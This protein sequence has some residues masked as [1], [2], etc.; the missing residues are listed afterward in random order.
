MSHSS[1]VVVPD[2]SDFDFWEFV[3]CTKCRMP[4]A[5]E[6][7]S[8][9]VP[10]WLTECGHVICNNHLNRDQSCCQCGAQDIQLAP[11]QREMEAPMSDWFRPVPLA[12]D[13]VLFAAKFQQDV[14][15]SQIRYHKSR[16]QQFRQ[17]VERMK[18]DMSD[19]KKSHD[20]LQAQIEGYR[21]QMGHMD[22]IQN[23]SNILNSNG[24]RQMG[25]TPQFEHP[26]HRARTDSSPRLITT[27]LGPDRLTLMPG[28]PLPELSST[29]IKQQE[30]IEYPQF[31]SHTPV[32]QD[33]I[34][35]HGIVQQRPISSRSLEHHLPQRPISS[36]SLEQY[37][38]SPQE[39]AKFHAPQL[40]HAQ[41]APK[42]FQRTDNRQ[43]DVSVASQSSG[44]LNNAPP[45]SSRFKPANTNF[46]TPF[47]NN[48]SR[49]S[50]TRQ[51]TSMGP[52]P[53]PQ[54]ARNDRSVPSG[55]MGQIQNLISSGLSNNLPLP[56]TDRRHAVSSAIATHP[57]GSRRFFPETP[58]GQPPFAAGSAR[59]AL[60]TS[61]TF[62]ANAGGQKTPL[63]PDVEQRGRFG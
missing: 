27:P 5:L 24:K 39:N 17:L 32:R 30:Q 15:A 14:M 20:M 35:G 50:T 43:N 19:L 62:S 26:N 38:Y 8:A 42:L 36:R 49:S 29:S 60:R 28:Q 52:P 11:L 41:A 23:S 54:H 2:T 51:Q 12:L 9:T 58:N 18:R 40:T 4:F 31:S 46:S 34:N 1:P 33:Y 6:N 63:V 16:H 3:S 45:T 21:R 48:A 7:G 47:M 13:S 55:S 25:S 37:A 22:S 61:S 56:L 57:S 59:E 44:T 53:T 10:F